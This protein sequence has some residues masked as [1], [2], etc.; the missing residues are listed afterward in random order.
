MKEGDKVKYRN[1]QDHYHVSSFSNGN[2]Y[3][4]HIDTQVLYKARRSKLEMV[5][6]KIKYKKKE[7]LQFHEL[8]DGLCY[9]LLHNGTL[10]LG[11]TYIINNNGE[12]YNVTKNRK[13]KV[14][15]NAHTR[16]ILSNE[17]IKKYATLDHNVEFRDGELKVGCQ[18]LSVP[19]AYE[20]ALDIL[21]RY[22]EDVA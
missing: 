16:F 19:D 9:R 1:G 18:T 10:D 5:G 3:I 7:L 12:L 13:S 22:T 14:G 6:T 2:V 15:F 8:V 11:Y 4:R 17:Y 21:D 20:L